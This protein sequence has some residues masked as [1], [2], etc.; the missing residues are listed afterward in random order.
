MSNVGIVG[1]YPHEE[2]WTSF[3]ALRKCFDAILAEKNITPTKL[4]SI[5]VGLSKMVEM[6]AN[7]S[8]I[9]FKAYTPAFRFSLSAGIAVA[10]RNYDFCSR[11]NHLFVIGD[12]NH[13]LDS[14]VE[15]AGMKKI[16][17]YSYLKLTK[18]KPSNSLSTE[19]I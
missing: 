16:P 10:K 3:L 5:G 4:F 1:L 13:I 17:V 6:Y 8:E 2:S 19:N 15:I 9:P 12:S 11:L 18:D 7:I 14:I